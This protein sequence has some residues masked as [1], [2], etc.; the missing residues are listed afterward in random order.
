MLRVF[1]NCNPKTNGEERFFNHIKNNITTI[2][3]VGCRSD[4]EFDIFE[5]DVHYFEPV[6]LS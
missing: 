5:G 2:F 4:T 6:T 3:D 1:N